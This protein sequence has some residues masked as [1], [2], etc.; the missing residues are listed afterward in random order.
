M[1]Q[2]SEVSQQPVA[3]LFVLVPRLRQVEAPWIKH[4]YIDDEFY[5]LPGINHV[6][7]GGTE[8]EGNWNTSADKTDRNR[9][10]EGCVRLVPS[11][12]RATVLQD[13]VGLRPCRHTVRLERETVQ[14]GSKTVQI[15]HNYGHGGAGI[16]LSWGCA[17]DT[18]KLVKDCVNDITC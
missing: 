13:T 4:F 7:L 16:T 15:V 18:V 8:Q 11:L 12:K 3:S 2:I 5:V 14:H 9:I 1:S 6:T 10:W 17:L